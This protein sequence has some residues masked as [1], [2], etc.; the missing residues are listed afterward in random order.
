M[1]SFKQFL[2]EAIEYPGGY[3]TQS[4]EGDR[5]VAHFNTPEERKEWIEDQ[6]NDPNDE[7]IWHS[8]ASRKKALHTKN[9]VMSALSSIG[10]E[11]AKPVA[12]TALKTALGDGL[13][14]EI[15]INAIEDNIDKIND[16]LSKVRS[17]ISELNAIIQKEKDNEK[18][19][20]LNEIKKKKVERANDLVTAWKNWQ[21]RNAS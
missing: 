6:S 3:Y 15:P 7:L 11:I 13:L 9:A 2:K 12:N 16:E 1:K 10:N 4:H 21:Q 20:K 17:Q 14:S 19:K 8:D 18:L 5:L